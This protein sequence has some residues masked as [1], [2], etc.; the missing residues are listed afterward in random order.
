M[1]PI[2]ILF[3]AELQSILLASCLWFWTFNVHCSREIVSC[4]F[5]QP[6]LWYFFEIMKSCLSGCE[7]ISFQLIILCGFVLLLLL[8]CFRSG[9][10]VYSFYPC[11]KAVLYFYVR[12]CMM[13]IIY[14]HSKWAFKPRYIF[15][16]ISIMLCF[17]LSLL[18]HFSYFRS[19]YHIFFRR[20]ILSLEKKHSWTQRPFFQNGLAVLLLSMSA[21][22]FY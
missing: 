15:L 10:F 12:W 13:I 20:N 9:T 7:T 17:V 21:F 5:Q 18:L 11:D 22:E 6:L 4:W 16:H 19:F 1:L 14:L 2:Q 3:Y 8:V